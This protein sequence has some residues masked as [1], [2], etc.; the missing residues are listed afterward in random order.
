LSAADDGRAAELA[1]FAQ[2]GEAL[3][4]LTV[5]WETTGLGLGEH[6]PAVHDHVELTGLTRPDLNVLGEAGF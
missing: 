3:L 5:E 2:L 4:D 6:L 1:G